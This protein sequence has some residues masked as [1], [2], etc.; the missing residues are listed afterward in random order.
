MQSG[1]LLP[2]GWKKIT[3][4]ASS[5]GVALYHCGCQP[6]SLQPLLKARHLPEGAYFEGHCPAVALKNSLRGFESV[7][8]GARIAHRWLWHK[9]AIFTQLVRWFAPRL[10]LG[11]QAVYV[12]HESAGSLADLACAGPFGGNAIT[13]GL[14]L[15]PEQEDTLQDLA[16]PMPKPVGSRPL[17]A[18]TGLSASRPTLP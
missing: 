10:P 12:Q 1:A 17:R 3:E 13:T 5:A 7:V 9:P 14:Q 18:G 4:F 6:A 8:C 11:L 16:S 2:L 15:T